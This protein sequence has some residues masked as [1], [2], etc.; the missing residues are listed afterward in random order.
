MVQHLPLEQEANPS[1]ILP[2]PPF[3]SSE[4]LD[5]IAILYAGDEYYT[6][7]L[8]FFPCLCWTTE[9]S[10]EFLRPAVHPFNKM[11]DILQLI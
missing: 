1:T 6:L 11:N 3:F 5:R 7:H 8:C 10:R 2:T 9:N 4:I